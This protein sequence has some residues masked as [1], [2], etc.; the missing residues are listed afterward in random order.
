MKLT[1]FVA[2]ALL[3]AFFACKNDAP[4]A[5]TTLPLGWQSMKMQEKTC[6][7]PKDTNRCAEVHI[8]LPVATGGNFPAI[9]Q[10]I[11]D[12]LKKAAIATLTIGEAK[13]ETT[14]EAA[15]KAFMAAFEKDSKEMGFPGGYA[16]DIQGKAIFNSSKIVSVQVDNYLNQ[17]GAHPSHWT[18]LY[19]FDLKNGHALTGKDLFTD[20]A[21]VAKLLEKPFCELRKEENGTVPALK[22]LLLEGVQFALPE[23]MAVTNEGVRFYYNPYE[24]TAYALGDFDILLTWAQLGALAKKETFLD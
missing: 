23:N 19:S 22:E 13:P 9:A 17:G 6:L 10:S 1:N 11:N 7:S 12:T 2:S 3:L 8:N 21:A 4:P 18:N 20:P 24:M 14:I 15:A 16:A 5:P